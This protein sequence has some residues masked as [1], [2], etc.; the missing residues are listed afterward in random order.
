MNDSK[1][2]NNEIKFGHLSVFGEN[3]RTSLKVDVAKI[4]MKDGEFD[5]YIDIFRIIKVKMDKRGCFSKELRIGDYL[6]LC[7]RTE[8]YLFQ[9]EEGSLVQKKYN[10]LKQKEIDTPWNFKASPI[11]DNEDGTYTLLDE[12]TFS[13]KEP[14]SLNDAIKWLF[15]N[16]PDCY[17]GCCISKDIPGSDFCINAIPDY[18]LKVYGCDTIKETL[19]SIGQTKGY[20]IEMVEMMY[21]DTNV[22]KTLD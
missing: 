19:I 10:D 18:Y 12:V 2:G 9:E 22:G 14:S 4:P 20:N 6:K 15:E 11:V 5:E 8:T 17:M 3:G 21:P 13:S 1:F 16:R 7:P